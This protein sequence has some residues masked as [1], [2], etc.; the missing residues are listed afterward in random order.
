MLRVSQKKIVAVLFSLQSCWRSVVTAPKLFSLPTQYFQSTKWEERWDLESTPFPSPSFLYILSW[1]YFLLCSLP[2]VEERRITFVS[3]ER[4]WHKLGFQ[5]APL[6][7]IGM[8]WR[9]LLSHFSSSSTTPSHPL[10]ACLCKSV[11]AFHNVRRIRAPCGSHAFLGLN[12]IPS[13][14]GRLYCI[15]S[16]ISNV[17]TF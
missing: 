8:A 12:W 10:Q 17:C 14:E 9:G 4:D 5:K 16:L 6:L 1:S 3:N 11:Q 15:F 13:E 2:A 7:F